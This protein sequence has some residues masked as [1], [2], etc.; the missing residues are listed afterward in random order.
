[1]N[2]SLSTRRGGAGDGAGR[3]ARAATKRACATPDVA[4]EVAKGTGIHKNKASRLVAENPPPTQACFHNRRVWQ[5]WL[6]QALASGERITRLQ[7]TGKY[8]GHR[9]LRVVFAPD[10]NHCLDCRPS[11]KATME[12]DGRCFPGHAANTGR[13]DGDSQ[14]E[15]RAPPPAVPQAPLT[16]LH[17]LLTCVKVDEDALRLTR[18]NEEGP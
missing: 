16:W 8:G 14:L 5:D 12:R 15:P 17:P 4:A 10:L 3:P 2:Q 13:D 7:D 6:L 11:R 18:P 9:I 1:M